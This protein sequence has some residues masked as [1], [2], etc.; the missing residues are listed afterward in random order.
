MQWQHDGEG[1]RTYTRVLTDNMINRAAII[2]VLPVAMKKTEGSVD[3]NEKL[4]TEYITG[5]FEFQTLNFALQTHH[6]VVPDASQLPPPNTNAP[7]KK[8]KAFEI[9]LTLPTNDNVTSATSCKL[10]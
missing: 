2:A 4:V 3:I 10:T 7:T 1:S 9:D 8:K 5:K 6:F